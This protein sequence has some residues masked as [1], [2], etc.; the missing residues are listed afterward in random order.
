MG[1]AE[2]SRRFNMTLL[3]LSHRMLRG[4]CMVAGRGALVTEGDG[5]WTANGWRGT[6]SH[7]RTT[8]D[9]P[10]MSTFTGATSSGG[11][12]NIGSC[13]D[14]IRAECGMYVGLMGRLHPKIPAFKG[15]VYP[16]RVEPPIASR[17]G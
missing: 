16:G 2:K 4:I 6:R 9:T 1:W 5:K 15:E 8:H 7:A 3:G 10:W 13:D 14:V 17:Q 11:R 12:K